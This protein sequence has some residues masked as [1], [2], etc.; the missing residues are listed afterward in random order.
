MYSSNPTG[1][2]AESVA[3]VSMGSQDPYRASLLS[4]AVFRTG[5][6]FDNPDDFPQRHAQSAL[7]D[8]AV[9]RESVSVELAIEV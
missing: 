3:E 6:P 8:A 2:D 7:S 1:K 4:T 5:S 9:R